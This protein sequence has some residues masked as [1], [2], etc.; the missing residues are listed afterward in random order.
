MYEAKR[1]GGARHEILDVRLQHRGGYGGEVTHDLSE[2]VSRGELRVVYQPIVTAGDGYITGVEA[3]LRWVHPD[4]G[5]V[6]PAVFIPLA[7][8][9]G[10]INDI[11]RWVME[12]ACRDRPRLRA[13]HRADGLGMSLNVS[14][15]QLMSPDFAATVATVLSETATPPEDVTLELTESAFIKDGQRALIVLTD[16]KELGVSIAL[17]DFGTGYSSLSLLSRFPVDIVKIDRSFIANVVED[18][19]SH[20]IVSAVI[21]LSHNLGMTVTAEGVETAE[22]HEELITLGCDCCQG[23]H[24]APPMGAG[25]LIA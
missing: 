14:V 12:A 2:A 8:Q 13:S 18:P 15:H 22:Q 24:F 6:P 3:L 9:A 17:D 1:L 25:E 16:L 11:G 21:D 10:L 23:Y 20:A 19:A 7:E 5:T 4:R